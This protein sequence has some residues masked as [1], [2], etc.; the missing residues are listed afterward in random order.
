PAVQP[1]V[2]ATHRAHVKIQSPMAALDVAMF[3]VSLFAFDRSIIGTC[4]RCG[5]QCVDT[6]V[7]VCDEHAEATARLDGLWIVRVVRR[8]V[9]IC[10]SGL[11][12]VSVP[13]T[14]L[15]NL[16]ERECAVVCRCEVLQR[17]VALD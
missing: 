9:R 11:L 1:A 2:V 4:L 6:V 12:T 3:I 17:L 13:L 5:E 15:P 7:G 10:V 14:E 8:E 16:H